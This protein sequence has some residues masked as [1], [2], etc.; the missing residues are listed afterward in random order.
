MA[1]ITSTPTR[2]AVATTATGGGITT[3]NTASAPTRTTWPAAARRPSGTR[4]ACGS[5]G[6]SNLDDP[7]PLQLLGDRPRGRLLDRRPR[8]TAGLS[9]GLGRDRGPARS[10][11]PGLA[12]RVRAS[13]TAPVTRLFRALDG[14]AAS[15]GRPGPRQAATLAILGACVGVS[16]ALLTLHHAGVVQVPGLPAPRA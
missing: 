5:N 3:T 9:A 4:N 11:R 12:R 14:F 16:A 6:R 1:P 10:D 2:A 15:L 8:R 7:K 13:G